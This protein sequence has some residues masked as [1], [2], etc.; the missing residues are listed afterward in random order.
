MGVHLAD[1]ENQEDLVHHY[2]YVS[3]AS[4]LPLWKQLLPQ[5]NLTQLSTSFPTWIEFPFFS[6]IGYPADL[7]RMSAR[8]LSI[9]L[10]MF[11][12]QGSTI[13][14]RQ[15][16]AEMRTIVGAGRIPYYQKKSSKNTK[17]L[18]QES[19]FGLGWYWE[20]A[21]KGV[22]YMGH[23][24]TLLGMKHLILVNEKNTVGVIVL[25]NEDNRRTIYLS[26]ENPGT[27]TNI[28]MSLFQCF[29]SNANKSTSLRRDGRLLGYFYTVICACLA[30]LINK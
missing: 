2:A 23:S 9:F 12:N 14:T 10:R 11:M 13:V 29:E 8:S 7:W 5:F 17:E 3:N 19:H 28:H 18:L 6:I 22:R 4:Y 27:T 1:F 21:S 30:L 24:G 20:T 26:R 16:I 25:T 15:S